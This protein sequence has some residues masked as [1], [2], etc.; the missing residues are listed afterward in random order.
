MSSATKGVL[1]IVVLLL[2]GAM[3]EPLIRKTPVIGAKLPTIG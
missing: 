1:T 2:I 3:A